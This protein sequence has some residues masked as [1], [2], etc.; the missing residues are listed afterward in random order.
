MLEKLTDIIAHITD[1]KS[2]KAHKYS[3]DYLEHEYLEQGGNTKIWKKSAEP[4]QRKKYINLLPLSRRLSQSGDQILTYFLDGSRRVFKVDEIAYEHSTVKKLIYPVAAGQISVG[5][6]RRMERRLI[7]EKSIQE[8]VIALPE[9]ADPDG[10]PGF[11]PSIALELNKNSTLKRMGLQV[12]SVLSYKTDRANG[13][14]EDKATACVQTRM[15]ECEKGLTE[16]IA[17]HLDH[18]NYLIK[19]GSLEYRKK[20]QTNIQ[21]Y[22]WVLGV[23]KTF[24]PEACFPENRKN[25]SYIAELPVYHR[26][27]AACLTNPEF[28]GD[29]DFAVWYIRLYDK[30]CTRSAFDGVIKVEKMLVTQSEREQGVMDSEE[31]DILSAYILNERCPSCYGSDLRWP[32]HIYPV[33]LTERYIKSKYISTESFLNFF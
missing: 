9:V 7:P 14:L 22:R 29:I 19:D 13:T 32:N 16:Q 8:T 2:Y 1:G 17:K 10:T 4:S 6:C 26:T 28:I 25:P 33:Y 31:I 24:N 20:L 5:C 30:K 12:S 11:L 23:S 15:L 3:L 18:R 21:N 27:Q